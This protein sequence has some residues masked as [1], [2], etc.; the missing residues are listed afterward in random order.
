VTDIPPSPDDL[1]QS[2]PRPCGGC[3]VCAGRMYGPGADAL[4]CTDPTVAET[5]AGDTVTVSRADLDM[6][7]NRAA[8]IDGWQQFADACDRLR[9]A[10]NNQGE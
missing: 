1:C 7:M 2:G 8:C 4:E 6:V 9:A 3:F 5:A 10:L